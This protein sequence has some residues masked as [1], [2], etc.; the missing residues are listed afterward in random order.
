[1]NSLRAKNHAR[2]AERRP[3]GRP[4]AGAKAGEKVKDYPQLSV[5]VPPEIKTQV[6]ALSEVRGASQWHIITDAIECYFRDLTS[7]EQQ[8]V[9]SVLRRNGRA[10]A[11]AER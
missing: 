4:T 10:K 11:R 6:A 2:P 3:V 1:M 9:R 5:R 8:A 7:A